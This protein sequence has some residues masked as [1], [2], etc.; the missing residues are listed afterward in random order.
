MHAQS[1]S[2]VQ[3]FC[4]LMDC[5]LPGSSVHG[6]SQAKTLERV[7]MPSSRG[8][9]RARN[10]TRI[11]CAAGGFLIIEPPRKTYERCAYTKH[12]YYVI[13]YKEVE[14]PWSLLS[15]GDPGT[16][17]LQIGLYW[18][19]KNVKVKLLSRVWLFAAL[20]TVAYEAPPSTW[21]SRQEYWSGLPFPSPGDLPLPGIKPGSS[22]LEADALTSEPPEKPK[23]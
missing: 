19:C 5:N 16:S 1:L 14:H 15:S 21:F 12:K 10:W 3:V 20:W 4:S 9:S 11:S 2:C 6:I 8:Y 18:P 23:S 17:P 22:A 7:A 13:L